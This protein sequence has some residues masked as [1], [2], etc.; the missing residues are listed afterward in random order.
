M[1]RQ[2]ATGPSTPLSPLIFCFR[3]PTIFLA[4]KVQVVVEL[5]SRGIVREAVDEVQRA[6]TR[7]KLVWDGDTLRNLCGRLILVG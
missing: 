4:L 7:F 5:L 6:E 3:C 2:V 1:Q